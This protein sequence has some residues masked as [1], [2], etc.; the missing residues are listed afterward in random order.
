MYIIGKL[1]FCE[2]QIEIMLATIYSG[3]TLPSTIRKRVGTEFLTTGW[4]NFGIR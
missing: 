2:F 4:I 3:E 1:F